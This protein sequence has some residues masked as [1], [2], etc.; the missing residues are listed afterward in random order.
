[1]STTATDGTATAPAN[2]LPRELAPDLLWLGSCLEIEYRG[3]VL[4]S[5]TSSYLVSGSEASLLVDP[6][7]THDPEILERQLER[8]LVGRPPLRYVFLSHQETPHAGGVGRLLGQ[9]PD[10][11]AIGDVRDYHLFFPEHAERFRPLEVGESVE[12]GENPFTV[13]EAVIRDL[14]TTRWGYAPRQRALFCSDGYAYAHHHQADQCGRTAEEVPEL[15]IVELAGV[16]YQ[17]AL[18]WILLTDMEPY[19]ERLVGLIE[20]LGVDVVAPVHGLPVTDIQA[21]LPVTCQALRMAFQRPT[22]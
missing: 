11:V 15:D 19:I 5:Y 9:Y 13:V 10:A 12:L 8:A 3:S 4:H 20:E 7:I 18:P 21:N 22:R 14:N 16:F 17:Y 1:M 2:P 6:G